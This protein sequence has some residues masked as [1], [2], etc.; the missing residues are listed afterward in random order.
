MKAMTLPALLLALGSSAC[1]LADPTVTPPVPVVAVRPASLTVAVGAA[2][3][4]LAFVT[5]VSTD[6][7]R[8]IDW[9]AGDTA[10]VRV[11][12]LS[13]PDRALVA[14]RKAGTTAVIA[15][16]HTD[17]TVRASAAVTVH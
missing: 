5:G 3:T 7:D 16:W 10:V 17:P 12:T 4:I 13:P 2:D 11:T 14:G 1:I 9:S 8:T 6:A 15:T